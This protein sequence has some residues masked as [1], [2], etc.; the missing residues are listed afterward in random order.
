MKKKILIAV[1]S[2][3]LLAAVVVFACIGAGAFTTDEMTKGIWRALGCI[4]TQEPVG[5]N[6]AGEEIAYV[7]DHITVT[8]SDYDR[9]YQRAQLAAPDEDVTEEA[10]NNIAMREIWCYLGH[11][12]GIPDDDEAFQAWFK[13]YRETVESAD[14]YKD[15]LAYM[16]GADMTPEEYWQWAQTSETFRKEWYATLYPNQLQEEFQTEQA[17]ELASGETPHVTWNEYVREYK[18]NAIENEHLRSYDGTQEK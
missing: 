17:K 10:L 16:G 18:K 5:T 9:Y 8:K 3:I 2:V 7:G 4:E 1:F 12:A 14:N 15:V 6:Q 13:Q 11:E